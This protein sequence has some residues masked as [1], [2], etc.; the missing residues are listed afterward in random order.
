MPI[1][2]DEVR[3]Y[4]STEVLA[5]DGRVVTAIDC[6]AGIPIGKREE[7]WCVF[8]PYGKMNPKEITHWMPLPEPP[9]E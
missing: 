7:F 4:K 6:I 8:R 5:T 9:A 3:A 2:I 1:D